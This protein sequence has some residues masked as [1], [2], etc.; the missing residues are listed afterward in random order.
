MEI[1]LRVKDKTA[2]EGAQGELRDTSYPTGTTAQ[3]FAKC[4]PEPK[5]KNFHTQTGV[6]FEEVREMC[7]AVKTVGASTVW[8]SIKAAIKWAIL[9]WALT[10]VGDG[11]K[12]GEIQLAYI[13]AEEL[14]DALLDQKV[15]ATGVGFMAGFDMDAATKEV[16]RSNFSKFDSDGN[17]IFNENLKVMKGP[18]Y[19]TPN[20][21]P[22]IPFAT[23]VLN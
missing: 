2:K 10:S 21:L 13:D 18:N 8:K 3:W 9:K 16:D 7:D 15:T 20:L 1:V 14:L 17:P 19:T 22:Y 23:K 4:F 11:L 5:A 6:H 12:Q